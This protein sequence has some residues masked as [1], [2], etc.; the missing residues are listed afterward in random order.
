MQEPKFT[1]ET[2]HV[3]DQGE[4][5][6]PIVCGEGGTDAWVA[7][8]NCGPNAMANAQLF[9]RAAAVYD[10]LADMVAAFKPFTAKNIGFP[11]SE[12]RLE[13]DAQ[14]AAHG[15]AIAALAEA[16]GEV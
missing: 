10:A 2:L 5:K 13:Q 6:F 16:R 1:R 4:G 11:G 7:L 8:V 9:A 12:A 3:V 14:I 15:K